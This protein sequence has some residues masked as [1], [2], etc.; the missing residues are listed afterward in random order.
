[1]IIASRSQ[2][3]EFFGAFNI[4]GSE[5]SG[6]M[7]QLDDSKLEDDDYEEDDDDDEYPS[8]DDDEDESDD[9]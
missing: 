9:E 3:F 1:M 7:E 8:L 5:H 6:V 4:K 2:I